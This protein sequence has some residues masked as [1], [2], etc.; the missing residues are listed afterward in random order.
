MQ[1]YILKELLL[2]LLIQKIIEELKTLIDECRANSCIEHATGIIEEIKAPENLSN[3]ISNMSLT[4]AEKKVLIAFILFA[5]SFL[6]WNQI[7]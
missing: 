3:K 2:N 5:F 1:V 7:E 4:G 6:S